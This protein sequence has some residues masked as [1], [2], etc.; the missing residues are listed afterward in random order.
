MTFPI[1]NQFREI[2]KN[3]KIIENPLDFLINPET[4]P[5][6]FKLAPGLYH[7]QFLI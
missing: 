4:T 5:T 1:K 2:P 6:F 7:N 3:A